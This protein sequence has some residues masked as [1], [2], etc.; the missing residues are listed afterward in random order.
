MSN[1]LVRPLVC[2][3]ATRFLFAGVFGLLGAVAVPSWAMD[4]REAYESAKVNDATVRAAR[5]EATASREA[6]PQAKAQRLPN[7]SL[8][9]ARNYNDL[10]S[11]TRNFLGQ[12]T[13]SRGNYYSGNQALTVR[14]PL[15]RPQVSALVRQAQAQVEDANATLERT[16][17]ALVTRVGEAYFDVLLA[18]DQ[19]GLLEAQKAASVA[20]LQSAEKRLKG[21]AGTIVD[22]QEALAQMDMTKAQELELRQNLDYARRK[23]ELLL[24]HKVGTLSKLDISRFVPQAPE[25]EQV[26]YWVARAEESSPEM[27]AL[28]AQVEAAR[29]EI[30]KAKA[31]HKPTLDVVAQWSRSN[32]DSVTNVNSRYDNKTL[33]LQL[34]VPLYSGGYVSSTVRQAVATHERARELLDAARRELGVRVHK[35]F[36][37]MTEGVIRIAALEQA[38]KS[39]SVVAASTEKS[40]ELGTRTS[41]DVLNAEHKKVMAVR[42]LAQARYAYLVSKLHL[43]ELAGEDRELGVSS[44]NS[45]L[46]N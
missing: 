17:Q 32:S 9:A 36:R 35:E 15:Y 20:Q 8:S 7:V 22:V 31:G 34:T 12:P 29:Q 46:Q 40:Y 43:Q 11:E 39:A 28:R 38:V 2:V 27:I 25:P 44:V 19:I 41:L 5:A 6:L 10:T 45:L 14:M 42:D 4:F 37:G 1:S 30:D 23:L 13:K 26:E 33:G 16:E 21:G 3:S 18:E 24:G